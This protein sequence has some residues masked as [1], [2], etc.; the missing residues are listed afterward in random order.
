M[1]LDEIAKLNQDACPVFAVFARDQ[2]PMPG[3]KKHLNEILNRQILVT[4][5]RIT[6]SKRKEGTECLQMQFVLGG[7]VCVTFTGSVVLIDQIQNAK[8]N[9]KIPFNTVVV[10]RDKYFSFS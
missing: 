1:T 6:K 9:N 8:D 7:E 5:Y 2:L 4:D 10:K 3:V